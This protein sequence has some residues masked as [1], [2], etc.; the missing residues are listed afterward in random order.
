ME[1]T[2]AMIVDCGKNPVVIAPVVLD[3]QTVEVVKQYEHLG[4]LTGGNFTFELLCAK[5]AHSKQ[6][7]SEILTLITLVLNFLSL[8]Y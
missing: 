8:L 1:K 2:K 6:V 3:N 5:K 7:S 4:N